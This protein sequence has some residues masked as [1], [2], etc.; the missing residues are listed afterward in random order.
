MDPHDI[1]PGC[2]QVLRR[3]SNRGGICPLASLARCP[4]KGCAEAPQQR[5]RYVLG[6]LTTTGLGLI[7]NQGPDISDIFSHIKNDPG[8]VILC[9]SEEMARQMTTLMWKHEVQSLDSLKVSVKNRKCVCKVETG[10]S[11]PCW[12]LASLQGQSRLPHRN[13]VR[14]GADHL[15]CCSGFCACSVSGSS[16]SE[17]L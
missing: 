7:H 16:S 4:G 9:S 6:M 11:Q 8:K 12:L 2:Q 3:Q 14:D 1:T 17:S 13:K 10:G 5:L 15:E